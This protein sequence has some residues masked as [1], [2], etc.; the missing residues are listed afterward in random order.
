[1]ST[2]LRVSCK[3]QTRHLDFGSTRL[4]TEGLKCSQ[5]TRTR[6]QSTERLSGPNFLSHEHE[7]AF[8]QIGERE[9][10]RVP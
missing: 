9:T 5:T 3:R 10:R 8:D 4:L 6:K 7:F 1:M 2:G